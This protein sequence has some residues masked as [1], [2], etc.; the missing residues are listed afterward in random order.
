MGGPHGQACRGEEHG[1]HGGLNTQGS[2]REWRL[3]SKKGRQKSGCNMWTSG[4][5]VCF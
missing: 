4:F 2:W 5:F 1:V 3:K